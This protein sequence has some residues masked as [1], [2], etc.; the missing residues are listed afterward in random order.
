MRHQGLR[1]RILTA[2]YAYWETNAWDWVSTR[3][4]CETLR[5]A[6][7][8]LAPDFWYLHQ[9]GYVELDHERALAEPSDPK[10]VRITAAGIDH[11]RELQMGKF[12]F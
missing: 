8:A 2:M 3:T 10:W 12:K 5:L 9:R 11:Y 4:V 1:R 7:Q 6:P